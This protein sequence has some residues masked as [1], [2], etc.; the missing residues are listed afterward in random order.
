MSLDGAFLHCTVREMHEKKL[1]GARV[2]K[3]HQPSRDEIII[4]LRTFGGAEKILLSAESMSARV[5]LTAQAPEN[6]QHHEDNHY[7]N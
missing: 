4:T 2:E 1:I 7:C 5:C 6:P 3:I